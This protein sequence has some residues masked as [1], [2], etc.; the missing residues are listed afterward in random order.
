MEDE[1]RAAYSTGGH[2]RGAYIPYS[3]VTPVTDHMHLR[4]DQHTSDGNDQHSSR[5]A[6]GDCAVGQRAGASFGRIYG[7]NHDWPV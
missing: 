5:D 1:S 7:C 3:S 4:E 2:A 6:R